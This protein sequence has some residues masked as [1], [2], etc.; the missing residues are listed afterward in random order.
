VLDVTSS[1]E[2]LTHREPSELV[3]INVELAQVNPFLHVRHNRQAEARQGE[4]DSCERG[5][6]DD[7]Q[8]MSAGTREM[9]KEECG[10]DTIPG[11]AL[12]ELRSGEESCPRSKSEL[13]V[14]VL[15]TSE[16]SA[17]QDQSCVD[18]GENTKPRTHSLPSADPQLGETLKV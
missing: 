14:N 4:D 9:A 13:G 15:R 18:G 1:V 8:V 6:S 10:Q 12:D 7:C 5:E 17:A 16:N 11:Q 3:S 2:R